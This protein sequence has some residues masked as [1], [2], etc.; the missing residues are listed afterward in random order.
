MKVLLINDSPR[1]MGNTSL[2]LQALLEKLKANHEVELLQSYSMTVTPCLAC[3]ECKK[4]GGYCIHK[5]DTNTMLQKISD[6][7][8][9]VFGTPVF[10]IGMA[11]QLKLFIDKF[12]ARQNVF[13]TQSK[14]IVRLVVGGGGL[15]AAQYDLIKE[16]FASICKFL[17]WD[18]IHAA[19]F[20]A[21]GLGDILKKE[22]FDSKIQEIANAVNQ[23]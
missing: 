7:D 3:Y 14:K 1:R 15:K 4:N 2:A 8:C 13:R 11:G 20:S 21:Y 6:A 23:E 9:I 22:D 18:H 17:K 5:D 19:S 12:I 16:Q 10:W